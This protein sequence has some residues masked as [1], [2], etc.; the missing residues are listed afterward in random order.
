MTDKEKAIQIIGENLYMTIAVANKAGNPWIANLYYA[1]D[2]DFTFY[3]YSSRD[4]VHSR[5]IQ[6]NP[7]IAISIFNATVVG[8]A[9]DAVYIKAEAVEVTDERELIKALAFYGKKMLSTGFVKTIAQV[10]SFAKQHKDFQ[11]ISRLRL[12]KAVPKQIW[13]LAP[14]ELH[15]GK[16]VDRRVEIDLKE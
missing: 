8:D 9:V 6:E 1:V 12:Y 16:F 14:T 13:K 3:W 2:S 11:G 10:E 5:N 4:S 7:E 15:N